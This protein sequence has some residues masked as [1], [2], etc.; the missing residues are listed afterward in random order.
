LD[1]YTTI[2][3]SLERWVDCIRYIDEALQV[4]PENAYWLA[5]QKQVYAQQTHEDKYESDPLVN[6]ESMQKKVFISYSRKDGEYL[7]RLHVHLGFYKIRDPSLDV[8]DD[9]S[10]KVGA[11]WL[12]EI[13]KALEDTKVAV[14]LIS[15]DF[16]ASKFIA[17]EEL[18]PLL[19]AADKKGINILPVILSASAFNKSALAQFQAINPPNKP[20]AT[21]DSDQQ[22]KVWAELAEL[23]YDLVH[24]A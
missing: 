4:A 7:E 15:A 17:E 22:E 14:F 1:D 9:T 2:L 3:I 23:I 8:W 19:E 18:S 21:M 12:E 16:F 13:R 10:I 5:R 6:G 11:K 24:N 20:L